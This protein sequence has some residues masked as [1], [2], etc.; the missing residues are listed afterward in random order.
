M[1]G[2]CVSIKSKT[3]KSKQKNGDNNEKK[4]PDKENENKDLKDKE[5]NDNQNQKENSPK[6]ITFKIIYKDKEYTERVKTSEKISYLFTLIKKYQNNKYSEFD[7]NFYIYF[8][9]QIQIQ[10]F[11]KI[12]SY[13]KLVILEFFK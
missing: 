3:V 4:I 12:G 9:Q 13:S 11:F 8:N 5:T 1:G 6:E 2:A 10:N 7:L